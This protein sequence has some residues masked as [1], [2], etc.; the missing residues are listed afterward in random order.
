MNAAL[1][2]TK[3]QPNLAKPAVWA[4]RRCG[5]CGLL[6]VEQKASLNIRLVSYP[7]RQ[8]RS[9]RMFVVHKQCEGGA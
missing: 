5:R 3:Q 8:G 9:D 4:P 6:I 2:K 1:K 7:T